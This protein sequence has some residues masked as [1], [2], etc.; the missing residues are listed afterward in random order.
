MTR[1]LSIPAGQGQTVDIN[2]GI[3]RNAQFITGPM[4]QAARTNLTTGP[5]CACEQDNPAPETKSEALLRTS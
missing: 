5:Q 2:L 4:G 3:E 1:S